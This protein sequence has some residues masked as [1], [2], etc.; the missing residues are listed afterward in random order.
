LN[1][2]EKARRK[3]PL[4]RYRCRWEDYIKLDHREIGWSGMDWILLAQDMDPWRVLMNMVM[5]L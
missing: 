5:K 4:G 2:G 1:F 3:N